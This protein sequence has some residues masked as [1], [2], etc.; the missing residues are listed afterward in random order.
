MK[1]REVIVAP[2]AVRNMHSSSP[3]DEELEAIKNVL[4]ALATNPNLGYKIAFHNPELYRVDVGKFRIHY[5][6]DDRQIGVSFIGV[7]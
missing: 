4:A 3:N 7:Y 1:R 6:V 2:I 5:S